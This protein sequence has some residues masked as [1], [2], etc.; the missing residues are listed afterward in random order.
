MISFPF[1]SMV[2]EPPGMTRLV[3]I[4]LKHQ[5]P[6]LRSPRNGN[7]CPPATITRLDVYMVELKVRLSL[8]TEVTSMITWQSSCEQFG[9]SIHK[10]VILSLPWQ[11]SQVLRF[12]Q[13]LLRQRTKQRN[14]TDRTVG[15]KIRSKGE[16]RLATSHHRW[17]IKKELSTLNSCGSLLWLLA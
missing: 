5:Q 9:P 2:R 12:L 1:A 16:N 7:T 11:I 3:P 17:K 4:C 14:D 15:G 8:F 13:H 6:T 10:T